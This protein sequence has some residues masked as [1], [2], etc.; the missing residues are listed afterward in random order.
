MPGTLW[1]SAG[2]VYYMNTECVRQ[3][4][5]VISSAQ[6]S[7]YHCPRCLKKYPLIFGNSLCLQ[8][9]E[10]KKRGEC[11]NIRV[12]LPYNFCNFR[13]GGVSVQQAIKSHAARSGC[14]VKFSSGKLV[15][16]SAVVTSLFE[17]ALKQVGRVLSGLGLKP[18]MIGLSR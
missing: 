7:A 16:S 8:D 17:D 15:L 1:N 12:S 14:D 11:D 3:G 10:I 13:H 18:C 6:H 2:K 4:I 9:F 5:R